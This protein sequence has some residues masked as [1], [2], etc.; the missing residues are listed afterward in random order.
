MGQSKPN[1]MWSP[2]GSGEQ[3]FVLGVWVTWPRWPP[4]PYKPFKNLLLRNQM[5]NDI[6][7]WY[8]ALGSNDVCSN[9]DLGLTLT[10]FT[11]RS[12]LLPYAFVW[13]NIH[14]LREN[15]RKSFNGR[16]LH[17]MTRLTKGL[18]TCIKA[19]K[20][21]YKIRVQR[22]VFETCNK[23]PK[24][25]EVSVDIKILS[26]RDCLPLPRGYIHV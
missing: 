22:D 15:V 4:H 24:L 26:P 12:N 17:Q 8:A 11:A 18:Y 14:F 25:Q 5:A 23:W 19:W 2:H 6:G 3:K 21:M 13:E 7:A 20:N 9:D 10:F 1:F 16:N